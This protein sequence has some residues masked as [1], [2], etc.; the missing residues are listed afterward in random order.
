LTGLTDRLAT[1]R[2]SI[3]SNRVALLAEGA[4]NKEIARALALSIHT[5]KSHVAAL[6]EKLGARSRGEKP[7]RLRSAPAS[8]M[9]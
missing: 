8:V 7:S 6:I 3:V 2:V 5:V 9:V 4:S 1:A